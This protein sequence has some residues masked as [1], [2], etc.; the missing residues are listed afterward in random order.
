MLW[1][2]AFVAIRHVGRSFSPGALSLG[3]LLV[4]GLA[5]GALLLR[6]SWPPVPRAAGF[7]LLICGIGWF[8][9]YNALTS[10]QIAALDDLPSAACG[11]HNDAQMSVIER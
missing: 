1:G 11:H 8:G 7:R 3:R 2:S 9:V 6:G 5:L 10:E 4:G